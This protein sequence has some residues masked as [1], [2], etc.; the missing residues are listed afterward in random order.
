MS[1]IVRFGRREQTQ[2]SS[3]VPMVYA[4]LEGRRERHLSVFTVTA[5][6]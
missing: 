6:R 2:T 3:V 1:Y 4:L 5:D